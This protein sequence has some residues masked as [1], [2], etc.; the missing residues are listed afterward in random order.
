MGLIVI[1]PSYVF[2]YKLSV[3]LLMMDV[4]TSRSAVLK[5]LVK[6]YKE[7]DLANLMHFLIWKVRTYP[8]LQFFK[9]WHHSSGNWIVYKIKGVAKKSKFWLLKADSLHVITL[10]RAQFWIRA[11]PLE[12]EVPEKAPL[13][14]HLISCHALNFAAARAACVSTS[15]G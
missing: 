10:I 3:G 11:R 5:V 13:K 1:W 8:D 7:G 12:I 6:P 9:D 15:P 4:V 14:R 2:N